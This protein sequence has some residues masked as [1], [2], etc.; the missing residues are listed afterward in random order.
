MNATRSFA[1]VELKFVPS[2]STA[3]PAAPNAGENAEMFGACI[4]VKL[5]LLVTD[6]VPTVTLMVPVVAPTGTVATSCVDV[7]DVTTALVPWN[8]TAAL[9]MFGSKFVPVI[10]TLV[11]A[12]PLGGEKPEI[13]GAG[14]DTVKFVPLVTL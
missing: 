11:P 9:A 3:V 13:V 12:A 6:L 7:A 14:S 1:G 4:T 2:I 8:A 5:A 10:V